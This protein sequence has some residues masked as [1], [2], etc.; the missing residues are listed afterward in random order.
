ME[1]FARTRT[2]RDDER[3]DERERRRGVQS[4]MS[5]TV[6][7]GGTDEN[8]DDKDGEKRG[9]RQVE[10]PRIERSRE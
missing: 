4:K 9:R 6:E 1:G 3:K 8:E 10:D 2:R 7:P 5:E